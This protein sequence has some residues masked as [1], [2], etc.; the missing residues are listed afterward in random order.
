MWLAM[1]K[2]RKIVCAAPKTSRPMAPILRG[3][4]RISP[5][6]AKDTTYRI[7]SMSGWISRYV[8]LTQGYFILNC[9]MT[10]EGSMSV[11]SLSHIFLPGQNLPIQCKSQ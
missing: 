8:L 4:K 7:V 5:A 11:L 10:Y 6:S 9:P 2:I 3:L 1:V